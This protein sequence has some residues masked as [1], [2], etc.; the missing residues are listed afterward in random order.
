MGVDEVMLKD[1]IE[2]MIGTSHTALAPKEV[3]MVGDISVGQGM[4]GSR[5]RHM[6]QPTGWDKEAALQ[7][8]E[9][10]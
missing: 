7:G 1:G 2:V 10:P 9:M 6:L 3:D 5:Q 8:A 4:I